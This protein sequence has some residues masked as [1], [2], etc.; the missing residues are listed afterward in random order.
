MT[1]KAESGR[2]LRQLKWRE[3]N[4]EKVWAHVALKSALRRGLVIQRPCEVCGDQHSEAHHP[5]YSRPAHVMWLCRK[6]HKAEH[7]RLRAEAS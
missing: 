4:P 7:R 5:D 2:Y 3:R 1:D 6:H